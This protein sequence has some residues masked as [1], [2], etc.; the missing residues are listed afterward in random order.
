MIRTEIHLGGCLTSF[1]SSL[2]T[3]LAFFDL[4]C[5]GAFAWENSKEVQSRLLKGYLVQDE[6][7]LSFIIDFCACYIFIKMF[8]SFQC[9]EWSVTY[10]RSGPSKD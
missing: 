6:D 3:N 2:D 5:L 7:K 9:C 1:P 10:C 4:N 8:E